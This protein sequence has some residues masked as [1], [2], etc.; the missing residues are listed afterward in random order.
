ME[1]LQ[2]H[3]VYFHEDRGTGLLRAD[4]GRELFVHRCAILD[5]PDGQPTLAEGVRVSFEMG[6]FKGRPCAVNVRQLFAAIYR[7]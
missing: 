3:V 7:A 6:R 4:N 5:T 2:G 1:Q